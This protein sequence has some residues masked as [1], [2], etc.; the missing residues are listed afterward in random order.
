MWQ[1]SGEKWA[2]IKMY[3]ESGWAI[4]GN[5]QLKIHEDFVATLHYV[6]LQLNR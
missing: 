4:V 6:L 2:K 3:G 1:M 5:F